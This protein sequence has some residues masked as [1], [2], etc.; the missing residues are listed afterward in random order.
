MRAYKVPAVAGLIAF[1][2]VGC[3]DQNDQQQPTAPEFHTITG[4]ASACDF[5]HLRQLANSYFS[6]PVQQQV[7]TLIDGMASATTPY[8]GTAKLN[9]FDVLTKIDEAVNGASPTTADPNVGSDLVNHLILC[10]YNP[11]TEA[12]SYP[13]TFPE[14]FVISLTPTAKGAFAVRPGTSD[15]VYSRPT[16]APFS[17]ISVSSGNWGATLSG[18]T[19]ARVLF[20]GKPGSTSTTFDW[21]TLPKNAT[22]SPEIVIG[23]CVNADATNNQTT[24]LNDEHVGLLPFQDA[25]F[26]NPLTCSSTSATLLRNPFMFAGRLLRSVLSPEPLMAAAFSPGGVGGRTSGIGTEYGPSAVTSV[27]LTMES[28]PVNGKVGQVI[29]GTGSDCP[30]VT[31]IATATLAAGGTDGVPRA[32]ITVAAVNNNGAKVNLG[33]TKTVSTDANGVAEFSTLTLNKTGTYQ[34]VFTGEVP[35]RAL[36]G[37]T[38]TSA[39]FNQGPSK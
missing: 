28:Q 19:P 20:Y 7:K 17:G 5:T 9:G 21:K 10:M 25:A 14:S 32:S 12:A 16:S 8:D 23:I 30:P 3:S 38:I 39:K 35:G 13:A 31:V 2:L 4:T 37:F 11:S 24:L 22:F 18:N 27:A 1:V 33:G 29:C 6:T 26:L 34:L 36:T 15:V